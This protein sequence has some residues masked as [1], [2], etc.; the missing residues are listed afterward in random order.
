MAR[1]SARQ[2]RQRA[3]V[4]DMFRNRLAVRGKDPDYEYR[5]VNDLD[6]NIQIF[7]ERGWEM[8]EVGTHGVGEKRVDDITP[9]GTLQTVSAGNGVTA[10]LMRIKKEWYKEDQAEKAKY[11]DETERS[12]IPKRD[13]GFYGKIKLSKD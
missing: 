1:V 10:F 12:L 7:K 6:D 4:R 8:V 3:S 9:E 11:V 13:E 5:W 2:D